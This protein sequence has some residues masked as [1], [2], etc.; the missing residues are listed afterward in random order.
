MPHIRERHL[1]PLLW[2]SLNFSPIVGLFGHRQVGKT[3][4][5]SQKVKEYVT[6]D[7][8]LQLD[9]CEGQPK[10]YIANRKHP[11]GIDESQLSPALFPALKEYVRTHPKPGQFV[12]TGSVRFS[13]RKQIRES[14]TGRIIA[15]ELLPMDLS[16][17]SQAPLPRV[18][19]KIISHKSLELELSG[20]T[21]FKPNSVAQYLKY[22]G[23]PGL[24]SIRN[25]R[26]RMQKLELQVETLL[27]RDLRLVVATSITYKS[28]RDLLSL[29]ATYQGEPFEIYEIARKS[30]IS[31]P[32]LTKLIH[33]FE[34]MYLI[35]FLPTEGSSRKKVL[36]LEDQGEATYLTLR[37]FGPLQ[38]LIRFLFANL[39]TQVAYGSGEPSRIYQ[40]RNRGGAYIPLVFE[41]KGHSPLGVL[42]I[43]EPNPTRQALASARSFVERMQG[44]V[45]IA[46]LG[47]EDQMLHP[48]IRVIPIAK[49]V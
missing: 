38:D 29:L 45:L 13:S 3:T 48:N 2:E 33:A 20:S 9:L 32:T 43:L 31:V 46:H 16:E 30:Q 14:L 26:M 15:W 37:P 1:A 44:R 40:Y 8:S 49:L 23:L 6:L 36:F 28:L 5:V 7:E 11:F 19:A 18:L 22:G 39:R 27:E 4:L 12:L 25:E 42:P 41:Q 35:R 34:A 24:F 10:G 17:L 21:Y 47:K